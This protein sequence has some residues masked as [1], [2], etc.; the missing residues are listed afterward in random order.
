MQV[1][2]VGDV[3][4]AHLEALVGWMHARSPSGQTLTEHVVRD[5]LDAGYT[6]EDAHFMDEF[7]IDLVVCTPHGWLVYDTT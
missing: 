3:V 2:T 7:T 1:E 6:V 4:P 5:V